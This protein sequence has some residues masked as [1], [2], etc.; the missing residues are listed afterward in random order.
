MTKVLFLERRLGSRLLPP[1][2]FEI[3]LIIPSFLRSEILIVIRRPVRQLVYKVYYTKVWLYL[4]QIKPLLKCCIVLLWYFYRGFSERKI[5]FALYVLNID[6]NFLNNF[7]FSQKW[8]F[9]RK[10]ATDQI[11]KLANVPFLL[12]PNFLGQTYE[13][14]YSENCN[15]ETFS[16]TPRS[17]YIYVKKIREALKL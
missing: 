10:K 17:L 15:I 13:K 9:Y 16:G 11:H 14:A 6:S 2:D 1:A 5:A 12:K 3:F 4:R 8:K 7:V